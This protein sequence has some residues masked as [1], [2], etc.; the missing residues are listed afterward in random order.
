MHNTAKYKADVKTYWTRKATEL[1]KNPRSTIRDHEFREMQIAIVSKYLRKKDVALDAGCGN[2]Y[3]TNQY[4]KRVRQIMGI[5]YIPEFITEAKRLYGK[6]RKNLK[7]AEGNILD[8]DFPDHAFDVVLCERTLINLAH[9]TEQKQGLSEMRRVLKKNGL[10][11]L[12]EVTKQGLK[13]LDAWRKKYDIPPMKRH[14]HNRYL[15]EK[16]FE[17]YLRKNFTLIR[18]SG[19]G[20]YMLISKIAH[21]LLVA[22]ATPRYGAKINKIAGLIGRNLVDIPGTASHQMLYVWRK[23]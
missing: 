19:F 16:Q 5:D 9:W 8:I 7:F 22:P 6:K 23:K 2:G 20:T 4:A 15:D 12:V 11:I 17:Q 1:G 21:S 10:L 13:K 3:S 18:K 14:W